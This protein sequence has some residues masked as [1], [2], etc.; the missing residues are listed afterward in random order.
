ME[1]EQQP[2]TSPEQQVQIWAKNKLK[3]PQ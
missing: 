3:R 2:Q 1:G